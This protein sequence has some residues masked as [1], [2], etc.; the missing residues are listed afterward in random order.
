M[1][2]LATDF[3]PSTHAGL[4]LPSSIKEAD[5]TETTFHSSANLQLHEQLEALLPDSS[6]RGIAM[7]LRTE[8]QVIKFLNCFTILMREGSGHETNILYTVPSNSND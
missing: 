6:I 1:T 3:M 8:S 2:V 4:V 5:T 7:A